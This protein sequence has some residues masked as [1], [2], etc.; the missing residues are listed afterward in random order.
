MNLNEMKNQNQIIE[1]LHNEAKEMGIHEYNHDTYA[2]ARL[3][4]YVAI[5]NCGGI[6]EYLNENTEAA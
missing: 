2:M 3:A 5:E 1:A 4:T 6:F